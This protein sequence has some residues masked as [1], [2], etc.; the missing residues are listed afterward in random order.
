MVEIDLLGFNAE[1]LAQFGEFDDLTPRVNYFNISGEI[2]RGK[3]KGISGQMMMA[4]STS[5]I[6]INMIMVSLSAYLSGT[7]ATAQEI[8]KHSPY[9]GVTRPK[10]SDTIPMM[11]KDTGCSPAACA[12]GC[13]TVP[14]MIMAG[15]ASKKQPTTKKAPA[16]KK[17]VA[18]MPK[19]SPC[20]FESKALGIW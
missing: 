17:P 11:A 6:G 16:I 18:V 20:K 7:L 15:M 2:Q 10:A 14:T 5:S 8:I 9:G 13:M 3:S 1:A 19:P 12:K 4:Q